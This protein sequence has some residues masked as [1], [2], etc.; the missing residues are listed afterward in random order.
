ML[1]KILKN[2]AL[3]LEDKQALK[4][5]ELWEQDN[6]V[7]PE[8]STQ[9]YIS[10]INFVTASIAED[11]LC[12]NHTQYLVSDETGRICLADL[13]Y[14]PCRIKHIRDENSRLVKFRLGIDNVVVPNSNKVYG[15]EYAY[16]PP[17]V[18]S[19][20]DSILL[21]IGLDYKT[22]CYGVVSEYYS[23]KMQYSQAN[24]WEQKFKAGLKNLS[25]YYK[26]TRLASRRWL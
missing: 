8:L 4:D 3:I 14:T 26:E 11:F 2:I 1:S 12:Y 10:L 6:S 19:L 25:L 21:P 15:I 18:S 23:L 24:I 9:T 20:S 7:Q 17:D 16:I 13:R 5:I 22:L